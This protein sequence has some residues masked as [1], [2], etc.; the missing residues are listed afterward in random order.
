M[1]ALHTLGN[2]IFGYFYFQKQNTCTHLNC[3]HVMLELLRLTDYVCYVIPSVLCN[4]EYESTSLYG[5]CYFR[6]LPCLAW[7]L[8]DD[9]YTERCQLCT[10]RSL[11]GSGHSAINVYGIQF[12][13]QM[14]T[15]QISN[16][17]ISNSRLHTHSGTFSHSPLLEIQLNPFINDTDIR[18]SCV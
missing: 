1:V 16:L 15:F 2:F 8:L 5:Q 17:K 10:C 11:N 6:V 13:Q 12:P 18:N 9:K 7:P 4:R 14:W 3:P